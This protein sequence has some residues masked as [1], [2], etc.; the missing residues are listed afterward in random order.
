MPPRLFIFAL[1]LSVAAIT[2]GAD[3]AGARRRGRLPAVRDGSAVI[4]SR[5]SPADSVTAITH[6]TLI[7]GTGAPPRDDQTLVLR[8]RHVVASGPAARTTV[9]AGARVLDGR[10]RYVIPGLWDMH[11]HAFYEPSFNGV[12]LASGITRAYL[13]LE[14]LRLGE[15]LRV[16]EDVDADALGCLVP[17]FILQP[18]VENAL[19][20]AVTPRREGGTVRIAAAVDDEGWLRLDVSDDGPGAVAAAVD[21]A[22]GLGLRAVRQRVAAT[23]PHPGRLEVHTA[24][25]A[26]FAITVWLPA[27]VRTAHQGLARARAAGRATAPPGAVPRVPASAD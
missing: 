26:G 14:Q 27:R 24:P 23:M 8:G 2:I 21:T 25:G 4:A 19:R 17:P 12:L 10:G 13:A 11:V 15:R 1:V 3:D 7:D 22:R 5:T 6:V 9:P 18:C 20:H 16:L